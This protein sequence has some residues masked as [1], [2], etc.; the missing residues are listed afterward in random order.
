MRI[1]SP[2]PIRHLMFMA[3]ASLVLVCPVS[4]QQLSLVRSELFAGS[5]LCAVC[6]MNLYDEEGHDVSIDTHW[7]ST[8]MANSARDTYFLAK[9]SSELTRFPALKDV[10]H[11]KC[12]VCHMPMGHTQAQ[13]DG[14]I[15]HMFGENFFSLDEEYNEISLDGVSCTVCHQIQR[16]NLGQ[17]ASFSGGYAI[18]LTT[19]TPDRLTYGPFLNP[20]PNNMRS[21][22]GFTPAYS[23]HISSS[24]LC[25]TCH[26]LYTP[27]LDETG[28]VLG[29][30]PEQ[31]PFLEWQHSGYSDGKPNEKQCISCHMPHAQGAVKISL[32]PPNLDP[33][34]PFSQHHFVGGNQFMLSILEEYATTFELTASQN[35]ISE[36][37]ERTENQLKENTASLTVETV[38]LLQDLLTISLRVRTKTGHKFPTG[39]PSRRAWIHLTVLDSNQSIVFES[40]AP[41]TDGTIQGNDADMDA[42]MYEPHYDEITQS[43]QV[44]IYE[45]IMGNHKNEVTYTLLFGAGYLKDNRLL[46]N[47]FEKSTASNDITTYGMAAHDDNF[48]NGLDLITYKINAE[49]FSAPLTV[50]AELLYQSVSYPFIRDIQNDSTEPI[51]HMVEYYS[52]ADQSPMIISQKQIDTISPTTSVSPWIQHTQD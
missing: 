32:I 6:H 46:P 47:G 28:A 31:T 50:T 40:G 38:S 11:D 48:N 17:P 8:M 29:E 10:I 44:Q 12:S 13:A 35:Q 42:E 3:I 45:S 20:F 2:R 52:L 9:V 14:S 51:N 30:F 16:D 34:Q 21:I 33:L 15:S 36:T 23:D 25:A 4:S 43:N 26:T 18:D 7:R 5:G 37:M 39:F 19:Q 49:G 27:Y 1:R 41:Q 22:S 24:A